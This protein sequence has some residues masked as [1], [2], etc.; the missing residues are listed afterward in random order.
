MEEV[1]RI[2][3]NAMKERRRKLLESEAFEICRHFGIPVPDWRLATSEDE[4]VEYAET[5]G[6]PVAL[7]VVSPDIAHKSDI[8][9]VI[10]NVNDREG[11]VRSY[12]KIMVSVKEKA[13]NARVNGILVQKMCPP[14]LEVI[15][16]ATRD[17]TF[18][19]VVMFGL[20]GV[21]VEVLGDVSFR[22][23]PITDADAEEMLGEI[24]GRKV[25]EG[26]RGMSRRDIGFIKELLKRVSSLM[27]KI[28]Y[29]QDVDLNPCIIY[30][31]G[32]GGVVVDARIVL[33]VG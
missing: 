2:I 22:V 5:I 33:R 9:G 31:E 10:L 14:A 28:E 26:Y 13:P 21:F 6:Y 7:K 29:I 15:V 30:E 16:G 4:A 11:V 3:E 1:E 8:G 24:K 17:N 20:G 19:P 12:R 25:L 32:K 18:G 23:A 27:V